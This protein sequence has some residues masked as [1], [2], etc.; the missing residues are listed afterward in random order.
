MSQFCTRCGAKN[1]GSAAFCDNCG[2]ALR[3]ASAAAAASVSSE[4]ALNSADPH[5]IGDVTDFGQQTTGALPATSRSSRKV[6]YAG[7]ALAAILLA[8]GA[9]MYM[10]LQAPA[11]T[12]ANLLAAARSGYDKTRLDQERKALCLSNTNYATQPLNVGAQDQAFRNWMDALVLAGLYRTPVEVSSGGF[13]PQA[14]MQYVATPELEKYR[15]GSRLCLAR[16][17]E[18]V[19][20]SDIQKPHE[21]TT[22]IDDRAIKITGVRAQMTLQA[23]NLAPWMAQTAVR[24]VLLERVPAWAYKDNKL[25]L[26]RIENFALLDKR[27]TAGADIEPKLKQGVASGQ[28][29]DKDAQRKA[30][31]QRDARADPRASGPGLGSKIAGLF[32]FGSHPLKGTWRSMATKTFGVDLPAGL[33]PEI[34][35]TADSMESGG[36]S[37]LCDFEVDGTRVKV[38]PKGQSQSLIFVMEGKDVMQA[39]ALGMRYE[40]VQ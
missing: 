37:T 34:T 6:L 17:V 5:S 19:E 38:T 20:L 25:Q 29:D 32:S 33:A 11:P 23:L 28:Y 10:V 4:S 15:E 12:P 26:R 35:F 16:G 14:L 8:G 22:E 39:K 30:A 1:E 9:A 40:R 7:G 2:H 18:I 3:G 21:E 13:F 24:T 36:A 31:P 27:W